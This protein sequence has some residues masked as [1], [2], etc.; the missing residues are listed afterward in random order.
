[1]RFTHKQPVELAAFPK[2]PTQLFV[3]LA[4]VTAIAMQGFTSQAA[5]SKTQETPRLKFLRSL[6]S[7]QQSVPVIDIAPRCRKEAEDAVRNKSAAYTAC[8]AKQ[9]ESY[10]YL[11]PIWSF[12]PI[13]ITQQCTGADLQY[14]T[15]ALDYWGIAM[16]VDVLLDR[17]MRHE[18]PLPEIQFKY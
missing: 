4:A 18:E 2:R 14:T 1:M 15:P 11:K 6:P 3:A 12:I 13:D 7:T 8:F 5:T 10:D 16:C 17:R 9:Q